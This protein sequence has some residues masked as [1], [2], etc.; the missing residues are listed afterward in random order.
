LAKLSALMSKLFGNKPWF[1][2]C[3]ST[4]LKNFLARQE[5]GL[6]SALALSDFLFYH[7]QLAKHVQRF[8]GF[9]G[10]VFLCFEEVSPCARPALGVGYVDSYDTRKHRS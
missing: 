4:H 1:S 2:N 10:L 9:F 3:L 7:I 8:I 5:L 6:S